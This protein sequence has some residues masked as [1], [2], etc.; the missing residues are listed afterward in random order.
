MIAMPWPTA[1][2]RVVRIVVYAR[3][4]ICKRPSPT[5]AKAIRRITQ[6]GQGGISLT[7]TRLQGPRLGLEYISPGKAEGF[8][9]VSRSKRLG[10]DADAAPEL[11]PPGRWLFSQGRW[12]SNRISDLKA[13]TRQGETPASV[14]CLH[15]GSSTLPNCGNTPPQI[16][17]K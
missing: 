2:K 6:S 17:L 16:L 9:D 3:S 11:E 10:G 13:S 8:R 15:T 1:I 4:K 12:R 5:S 7:R 14:P